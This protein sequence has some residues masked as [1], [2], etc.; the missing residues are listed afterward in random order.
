MHKWISYFNFLI[1][2]NIFLKLLLLSTS[3]NEVGRGRER[4]KKREREGSR[5]KE[6]KYQCFEKLGMMQDSSA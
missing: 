4:E 3:T 6:R 5:G 2:L 1:K